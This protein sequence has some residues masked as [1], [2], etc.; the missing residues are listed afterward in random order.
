VL[1]NLP[2]QGRKRPYILIIF[3]KQIITASGKVKNETAVYNIENVD[4]RDDPHFA[5][6]VAEK[7]YRRMRRQVADRTFNLNEYFPE[8]ADLTLLDFFEGKADKN[9]IR[10]GGYLDYREACVQR[11]EIT[12]NTYRADRDAARIFLKFL[13]ENTLITSIDKKALEQFKMKILTAKTERKKEAFSPHSINIYLATLSSAFSQAVNEDI[14]EKNPFGDISKIETEKV[15]RHLEP[16]EKKA[17]REYLKTKPTWQLQMFD[18][19]LGTGLR[20]DEL[21]TV[22]IHSMKT[23]LIDGIPRNF[24][25]AVGKGKRG[26]KKVRWVPCDDVMDI[27]NFRREL[28]QDEIRMKGYIYEQKLNPETVWERSG[29]GYLFFEIGSYYSI[30]QFI[31]RARRELKLPENISTH[32]LRHDFAVTVLE[33]RR[34]PL[35]RLMYILGHTTIEMTMRYVHCTP[36]LLSMYKML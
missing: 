26:K 17:L 4:L 22:N 29:A 8:K 1:A 35:E 15:P 31:R 33:E 5:L 13:G 7:V 28:M 27:I 25:Q 3:D 2:W 30:S 34:Y 10:K 19:D 9:G 23:E 16:G 32:S 21:F 6:E 18:F 36:K 20:A 12:P 14:I 24:I 11:K